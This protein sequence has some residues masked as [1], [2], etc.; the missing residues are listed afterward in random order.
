MSSD[1]QIVFDPNGWTPSGS[2]EHPTLA[3]FVGT[4]FAASLLI[5]VY[6]HWVK[7][8]EDLFV[9]RALR[10]LILALI[11]RLLMSTTVYIE[12][13]SHET[14]N[15]TSDSEAQSVPWQQIYFEVPFYLFLVVPMSLLFS[16][17]LAY[18]NLVEFITHEEPR[19]VSVCSAES[20]DHED[21]QK[22]RSNSEPLLPAKPKT[23]PTFGLKRQFNTI[24]AVIVTA[25]ASN[26]FMVVFHSFDTAGSEA[27]LRY[28]LGN[29]A[30][31]LMFFALF[32]I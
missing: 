27:T 17:K 20:L 4:A 24:V 1:S 23:D 19:R 21:H 25:L 10:Y 16:W 32:F 6:L 3:L 7:T 8:P 18:R 12:E 15:S 22:V 13:T 31:F 30:Y 29:S 26:S 11:V 28:K 2:T 9:K 5:A 14:L